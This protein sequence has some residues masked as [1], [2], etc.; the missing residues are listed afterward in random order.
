MDVMNLY[1]D[2]HF[3]SFIKLILDVDPFRRISPVEALAHPFLR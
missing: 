1:K 2:L 3:M